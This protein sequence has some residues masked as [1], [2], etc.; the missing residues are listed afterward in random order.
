TAA[1]VRKQR[2]NSGITQIISDDTQQFDRAFSWK[3]YSTPYSGI[4]SASREKTMR[5]GNINAISNMSRT[6]QV[7]TRR[8]PPQPGNRRRGLSASDEIEGEEASERVLLGNVGR[9]AIVGGDRG[10]I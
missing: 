8:I 10:C 1:T 4:H 7:R 2:I 3:P 6:K 5:D 9:P